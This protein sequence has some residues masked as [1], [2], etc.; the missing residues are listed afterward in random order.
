MIEKHKG[1]LFGTG[2]AAPISC[3]LTPKDDPVR[4]LRSVLTDCLAA[5]NT[6]ES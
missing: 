5:L 6:A 4:V 3:K 2:G 1:R